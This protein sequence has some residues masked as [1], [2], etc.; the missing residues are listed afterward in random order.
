MIEGI[1]SENIIKGR[2]LYETSWL[3]YCVDEYLYDDSW[4]AMIDDLFNV[5]IIE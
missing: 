4:I 3:I 1:L 2:F 5:I